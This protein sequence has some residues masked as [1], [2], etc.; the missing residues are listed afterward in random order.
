[1]GTDV[2]LHL[3]R[4]PKVGGT[5][6]LLAPKGVLFSHSFYFDLDTLY[7]KRAQIFPPELAKSITEGEQQISRFLIGSS[8]PKFLAQ[9]GLH[10]RLVATGPEAVA[11]YK[12]QPDQKLPAFA[13][14]LSTRDP[15]F[16]KTMTALIK[17][18]ALAAGQA[19]ALKPW[20]EEIAGVPAFGYSFPENGKFPDDPQKLRFNYQPTFGAYKGQYVLAS[21]K[22]LFRDLVGQLD[23]E[24]R[25]K[26]A[27]QNMQMRVYAGGAAAYAS[28]AA[29]QALAA[30]IVGQAVKVGDARR[31]TEALFDYLQ[32][33]G[34]IGIETTYTANEF[35]FDAT[36]TTRK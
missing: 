5:L 10:Y 7:R 2:E 11:D 28:T 26:V 33:L 12:T 1:M 18:A 36:W 3:P 31:Q 24:D 34:T 19:A 17:A 16:A 13:A 15:G 22:G 25:T 4:D 29:D 21:N 9:S 27:P 20:D 32:K 23:R 8:L 14:V 30:T 6:P 35:R